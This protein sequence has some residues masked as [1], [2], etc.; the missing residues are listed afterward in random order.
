VESGKLGGIEHA[1]ELGVE[2]DPTWNST[3]DDKVRDTHA[4][5]DGQIAD[6][7]G[8]FHSPAGGRAKYP[9]GFGIAKEDCNC[10]CALVARPKGTKPTVRRIRGEGIV[11]YKT[12]KE[13]KEAQG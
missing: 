11:T 13:W 8:Y 9:G 10:R 2:I 5:M 6:A 7:E 12:Y 1:E 3:L 4:A